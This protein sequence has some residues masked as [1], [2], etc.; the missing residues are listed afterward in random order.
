MIF[1]RH[2]RLLTV[3]FAFLIAVPSAVFS[4]IAPGDTMYGSR[5][6]ETTGEWDC[7]YDLSNDSKYC[8]SGGVGDFNVGD[9][10]AF[11]DVDF[12]NGFKYLYVYYS[13][14]N[15]CGCLFEF[16]TD[17]VD[18]GTLIVDNIQERLHTYPSGGW[19]AG[20][21]HRIP[22]KSSVT[23]VHDLYIKGGMCGGAD[24]GGVGIIAFKW[25]YLSNDSSGYRFYDEIVPPYIT[26]PQSATKTKLSRHTNRRKSFITTSSGI[27]IDLEQQGQYTIAL[28]GPDGSLVAKSFQSGPSRYTLPS[29]SMAPGMYIF[30][31]TAP[32]KK[33]T[34]HMFMNRK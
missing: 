27:R 16:R 31:L 23:G 21:I 9:W 3:C 1:N 13:C 18:N 8:A 7:A 14:G 19:K 17:D 34:E 32:D 12:A 30:K 15:L 28:Y 25:I 29:H 11:Q 33:Q 4:A 10:I 22:V 26:I 2:T 5:Y 20:I 6:N 24:P